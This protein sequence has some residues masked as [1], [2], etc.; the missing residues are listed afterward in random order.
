MSD[1]ATL[2][3]KKTITDLRAEGDRLLET[4]GVTAAKDMWLAKRRLESVVRRSEIRKGL[5]PV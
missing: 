5:V 3:L 4:H 1:H 2:E